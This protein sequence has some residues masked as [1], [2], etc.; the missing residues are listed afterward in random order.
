[1]GQRIKDKCSQAVKYGVEYLLD[2]WAWKPEGQ[3]RDRFHAFVMSK[4]RKPIAKKVEENNQKLRPS[5]IQG[6]YYE[7]QKWYY[8]RSNGFYHYFLNFL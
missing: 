5:Q 8:A 7:K 3:T 4:R 1:M 6:C 2:V